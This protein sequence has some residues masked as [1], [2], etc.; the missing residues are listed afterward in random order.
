[1][2]TILKEITPQWASQILETHNP[3][4]R[5]ISLPTVEKMARDICS[6]AFVP[7]HQGIAFNENGDLLDGQHRL[8]AVVQANRAVAMLVTTGV[9]STFKVNGTTLNTFELIDGGRKRGVGQMLAMAGF[10]NAALLAA[11]ARVM[12]NIAFGTEHFVSISTPQAHRAINAASPSLEKC[13]EIAVSSKRL[14]RPS[15]AI[16]AAVAIYHSNNPEKAEAFLQSYCDMSGPK[17]CPTRALASWWRRHPYQGGQF[18]I[19]TAKV[20][21]SAL[22]HFDSGSKPEKLYASDSAMAWLVKLNRPLVQKL[23][24]IVSL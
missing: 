1:M 23:S 24:A 22:S 13:I 8:M 21:A 12:V 18:A 3:K 15:S 17:G 5:T 10:S 11:S 14:F 4:N 6:G 19:T 7:T 16:I 20:T 9:P 2:K